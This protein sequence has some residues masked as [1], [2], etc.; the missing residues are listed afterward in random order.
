MKE[1]QIFRNEIQAGWNKFQISR[2]ELQ[3]QILHFP[4][5]DRAFSMGYADPHR[6]FYF[7]GRS[8]LK[9]ATGA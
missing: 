1:T 6:L 9:G 7:L 8:G 5:P 2:N 4:S 3:I